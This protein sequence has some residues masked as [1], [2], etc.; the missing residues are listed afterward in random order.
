[1]TTTKRQVKSGVGSDDLVFSTQ[2][3]AWASYTDGTGYVEGKFHWF[4][5]HAEWD[6]K[7]LVAKLEKKA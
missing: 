1:M 7:R 2:Y 3:Y 6:R 5:F 4:K